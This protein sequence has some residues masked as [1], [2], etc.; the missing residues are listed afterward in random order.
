MRK[1]SVEIISIMLFILAIIGIIYYINVVNPEK[2]KNNG[3][4]VVRDNI[5]VYEK[6]IYG[7]GK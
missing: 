1:N 4:I 2:C 7:G 3:G 6:C 5:G